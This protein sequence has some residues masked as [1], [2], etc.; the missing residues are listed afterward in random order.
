MSKLRKK[1]QVV[2]NNDTVNSNRVDKC[3]QIADDF[4]VLFAEWII[5][6]KPDVFYTMPKTEL[7]QIFKDKYYE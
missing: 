1:F 6:L 3:E 7:L 2:F 4:A 5:T